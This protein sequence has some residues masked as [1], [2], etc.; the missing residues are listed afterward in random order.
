MTVTAVNDAPVC[1]NTSL[2]TAEDTRRQHA[3]PVCTDVDGDTLT[4]AIVDQ[5]DRRHGRGRLAGELQYTPDPNFN[6]TDSFT[7]QGQRRDRRQQHR[8]RDRDR[9]RRSTTRRSPE[10]PRS[11]RTRTRA[12]QHRAGCT[13]VDGDTLTYA[14]V[15]QPANGTAAVNVAG[16]L[17]VHPEPELQRHRLVHLQANDG[18]VDSNTA[19]VA[20]TVT[21]VN[22]APVCAER[23]AHDRRGHA[24]STALGLHRRRRR[25]ADLRDRRP[26]GQRHGRG[27]PGRR[28]F[29]YTPNPNFNGTDRSPTGQRRDRRQQHR[30]RQRDRQRRSTMPR[31]L[32]TPR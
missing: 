10:R 2:T 14:I 21:P 22:D 25:H 1:A 3:R 16:E 28:S 11:P 4:Y 19:T 7:Y 6:G 15:G 17:A 5:P 9:H 29:S 18:T 27:R 20:V 13:D 12:R 32:P 26:A 24:G 23:L 8:H 31:S 30:H